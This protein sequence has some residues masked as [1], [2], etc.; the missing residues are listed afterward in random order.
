[1][2]GTL[3]VNDIWGLFY[4]PLVFL[5]LVGFGAYDCKYKRVPDMALVLFLPVALMSPAVQTGG[6]IWGP[7]LRAL[8][9]SCIGAAGC[10]LILL[11]AALLSK[12]GAGLGGG[13]IKLMTALG[14]IYGPAGAAGILLIAAP[15][16]AVAACMIRRKKGPRP[17]GLPFVPFLALGTLAT[18][19]ALIL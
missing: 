1:M 13:D 9:T 8:L 18:T 12:D 7:L 2:I 10:F 4:Y 17:L 6:F 15:L 19:A 11:A 16:A 14:F 5:I 3:T